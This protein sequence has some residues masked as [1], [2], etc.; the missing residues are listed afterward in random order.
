MLRYRILHSTKGTR[1]S[2]STDS[3]LCGLLPIHPNGLWPGAQMKANSPDL[4]H[5]ETKSKS[6]PTQIVF[7]LCIV[8]LVTVC[9]CCLL[10]HCISHARVLWRRPHNSAEK[11]N[12]RST[13][14]SRMPEP[15]FTELARLRRGH[16][17]LCKLSSRFTCF[18][19]PH[20]LN[21]YE[22]YLSSFCEG[23]LPSRFS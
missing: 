19:S 22:S 10:N 8:F 7:W 4:M 3:F 13:I 16:L 23:V 15:T 17:P 9:T 12:I 11:C 6:A 21:A 2:L 1:W 14:Y 18:C 5:P 20:M